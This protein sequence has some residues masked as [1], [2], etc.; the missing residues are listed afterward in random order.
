M[1]AQGI[2]GR[3]PACPAELLG[4][5]RGRWAE[6]NMFKYDMTSYGLD[7]LADYTADEVVN[8]KLKANPAHTA[9]RN[10]ETRAQAAL[11]TAELAL[12][13]LLA[14]HTIAATTKNAIP[15]PRP[16]KKN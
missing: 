14:D 15:T 12:A 3:L 2:A 1:G 9:A 4:W 13:Q 16:H 7:T 5:L 6:E 10:A 11:A 8:T